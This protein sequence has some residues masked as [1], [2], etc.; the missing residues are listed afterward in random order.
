MKY[1]VPICV[2]K[3]NYDKYSG[4]LHYYAWNKY[5]I[6]SSKFFKANPAKRKWF[7]AELRYFNFLAETEWLN[8]DTKSKTQVI[9]EQSTVQSL[10]WD[11]RIKGH[12]NSIKNYMLQ[13]HPKIW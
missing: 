3:K 10:N 9:L 7:W 5:I 12:E 6:S 13:K 1:H 11:V 2:A 8:V 4:I